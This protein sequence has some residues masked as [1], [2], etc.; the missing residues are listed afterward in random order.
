[1]VCDEVSSLGRRGIRVVFVVAPDPPSCSLAALN[2]GVTQLDTIPE[3][4]GILEAIVFVTYGRHLG[5]IGKIPEVDV[6]VAVCRQMQRQ[7][8][9]VVGKRRTVVL[10]TLWSDEVVHAGKVAVVVVVIVIALVADKG[11]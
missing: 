3:R 1:M 11:E 6:V 10:I 7:V 9:E 5:A 4:S 2:E 8:E